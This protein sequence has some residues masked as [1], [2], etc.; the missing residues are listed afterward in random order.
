MV[1]S[2]FVPSHPRT[3]RMV[4]RVHHSE[5]ISSG[6]AVWVLVN[7]L[8]VLRT[9]SQMFWRP[10]AKFT[11][12]PASH[13]SCI[14]L[15]TS[16]SWQAAAVPSLT[17]WLQGKAAPIQTLR[18]FPQIFFSL[19]HLR[20]RPEIR[21]SL[22]MT[23]KIDTLAISY[24]VGGW[25]YPEKYEIVSWDDDIPNMMGKI[26]QMF[27]TTNQHIFSCRLATHLCGCESKLCMERSAVFRTY[28]TKGLRNW[29]CSGPLICML[30]PLTLAAAHF[31][32]STARH[33][34]CTPVQRRFAL[35]G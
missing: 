18:F 2:G 17:C 31:H 19:P 5:F 24:L 11:L 27:Q 15:H 30:K 29:S 22:E 4:P 1:I 23:Q 12:Q 34:C 14:L 8:Y 6:C 28:G 20:F 25:A 33:P 3:P 10:I 16:M 7:Q 32:F 9:H 13:T 35:H 26:I 21:E